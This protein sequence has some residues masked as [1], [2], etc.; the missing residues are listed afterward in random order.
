LRQIDEQEPAG[1]EQQ[2]ST[3]KGGDEGDH[4]SKIAHDSAN[5]K[6]N[7][8]HLHHGKESANLGVRASSPLARASLSR[9]RRF[10]CRSEL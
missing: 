8:L 9:A 10:A 5:V 2:N 6:E 1:G 3:Q 7:L 4:N